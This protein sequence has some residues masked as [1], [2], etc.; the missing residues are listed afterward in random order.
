MRNIAHRVN[1]DGSI[2]KVHTVNQIKE[3]EPPTITM[4]NQSIW[5][6]SIERSSNPKE[7]FQSLALCIGILIIGWVFFYILT[8]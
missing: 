7:G 8:S 2:S 3:E 4:R 6:H 1:R 5:M